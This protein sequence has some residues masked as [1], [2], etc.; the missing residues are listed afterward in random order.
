MEELINVAEKYQQRFDQQFERGRELFEQAKQDFLSVVE[1]AIDDGWFPLE[2]SVVRERLSHI[3]FE[4]IDYLNPNF[5]DNYG[6]LGDYNIS[7]GVVRLNNAF[8][9]EEKNLDRTRVFFHEFLHA[10]AGSFDIESTKTTYEKE[11]GREVYTPKRGLRWRS[12]GYANKSD[13][14]SWMDE[15][16]TEH[17]ALKLI[18]LFENG[19]I[20]SEQK[21]YLRFSCYTEELNVLNVLFEHGVSERE[22]IEAYFEDAVQTKGDLPKIPKFLRLKKSIQ[23]AIGSLGYDRLTAM[24][25]LENSYQFRQ[26]EK[27][28]ESNPNIISFESAQTLSDGLLRVY[29]IELLYSD[30]QFQDRKVYYYPILEEDVYEFFTD[31]KRSPDDQYEDFINFMDAFGQRHKDD[32]KLSISSNI[33]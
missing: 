13:F 16:V 1:H 15:A 10:I 18:Y 32:K 2:I 30:S 3:Q 12:P 27:D 9:S 33:I 25:R 23:N 22:F 14:Y 6:T 19:P 20:G 28:I 24:R 7:Q 17:M 31:T 21:S 4:L 26:I 5:S 29:E 8:L 11:V